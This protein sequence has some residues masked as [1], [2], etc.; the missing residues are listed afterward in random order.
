MRK[1][2]M[3]TLE[4]QYWYALSECHF[5]YGFKNR[6]EL[7]E[8][9][10]TQWVENNAPEDLEKGVSKMRFLESGR[11]LADGPKAVPPLIVKSQ[12]R[13]YGG[14]FTPMRFHF[15]DGRVEYVEAPS[16]LEGLTMIELEE[17]LT[18]KDFNIRVERIEFIEKQDEEKH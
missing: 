5:R 17:G 6:Q 13:V 8:N 7:I 18:Q 3:V 10:L 16:P 12:T 14:H 11:V 4:E 9:L 1:V 2:N 15:K